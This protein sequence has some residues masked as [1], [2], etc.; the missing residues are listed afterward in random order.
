MSKLSKAPNCAHAAICSIFT[1]DE[2]EFMNGDEPEEG[3]PYCAC[4][5]HSNKQVK[6][7]QGHK[8]LSKAE[9]IVSDEEEP[10]SSKP[11]GTT[12]TQDIIISSLPAVAIRVS[13]VGSPE[14]QALFMK[15]GPQPSVIKMQ[16][17]TTPS[18]FSPANICEIQG[19]TNIARYEAKAGNQHYQGMSRA[20]HRQ[21]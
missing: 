15:K 17:P 18:L 19:C 3:T 14:L 1:R 13:P 20:C 6:T 5:L 11:E 16:T 12:E 9:E 8:I 7:F 21:H 10:S 4:T 2:E